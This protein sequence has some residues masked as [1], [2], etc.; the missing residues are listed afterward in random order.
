MSNYR[1]YRCSC[2]GIFVDGLCSDCGRPSPEQMNKQE[3]VQDIIKAPCEVCGDRGIKSSS[4]KLNARTT[5]LCLRCLM[6]PRVNG[7]VITS[8]DRIYKSHEEAMYYKAKYIY[9]DN[10]KYLG[11]PTNERIVAIAYDRWK[12]REYN[13][14]INPE[15]W[16]GLPEGI[17]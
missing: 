9:L 7:Q 5:C 15:L 14:L 8:S 11:E 16:D 12:S 4:G 13:R 1:K 6:R 3:S 10:P 2:N 17:K